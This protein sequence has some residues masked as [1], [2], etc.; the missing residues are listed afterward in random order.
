MVYKKFIKRDGKVFGPYYYESYRDSKGHVKTRFIS[1]PKKTDKINLFSSKKMF[2]FII[3]LGIIFAVTLLLFLG[4]LSY[5]ARTTGRV[6]DSNPSFGETAIAEQLADNSITSNVDVRD[7]V[8][9][10]VKDVPLENNKIM[11][12]ST[13]NGKIELNFDLLNYSEFVKTETEDIVEASGFDINVTES[14]EKY[15]WGY[16]VKLADLNF[17]ARIDVTSNQTIT[18]INNQTL[19]IGEAYLSFADLASQGYTLSINSPVLLN[20]SLV[21]NET[22]V[23]NET[24][25]T[26]MNVSNITE[27]V[28]NISIGNESSGEIINITNETIVISNESEGGENISVG[29][30]SVENVTVGNET[31]EV[32]I[33][34]SIGED[35]SE[36][37]SSEV[38]VEDTPEETVLG[39]VPGE[40][41]D[42]VETPVI[43]EVPVEEVTEPSEPTVTE[44]VVNTISGFVVH[45]VYGLTGFVVDDS[46]TDYEN[47]VSVYVQKN[48]NGTEY[49]I[50][51]II[52]LDPSLVF[53]E[54]STPGNIDSCQKLNVSGTYVLTRN[55]SGSLVNSTGCFNIT[56]SNVELNCNG[57]YIR[58]TG[59][60]KPGI[61]AGN[62]TNATVRNCNITMSTSGYGIQFSSVN[63]SRIV[64]NLV[65]SNNEGIFVYQSYNNNISG[66]NASFNSD[67][68]L[69]SFSSNQRIINNTLYSNDYADGIRLYT[70]TNNQIINNTARL[71]DHGIYLDTSSNNNI[72]GNIVS[73]NLNGGI[74]IVFGSSNNIVLNNTANLN[75]A[76]VHVQS[77]SDYNQV[78]NNTL[79]SNGNSISLSSASNNNFTNNNIWNC[80]NVNYACISFILVPIIF[81]LEE[82]LINLWVI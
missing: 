80:T 53:F 37:N 14:K 5:N 24:N 65:G 18:V 15:K 55:L 79:N 11:E 73:S 42:V 36:E 2:L 26:E 48:F 21:V 9:L 76:G 43:D 66:N 74:Y 56:V 68:I 82:L 41:T 47:T 8:D 28:T 23:I 34:E 51:D 81:F 32:V 75:S 7:S 30:E 19:R 78:T 13:P 12:F 57:Y 60:S 22:I 49:N 4:N 39:E 27:V 1:G 72:T 67:G 44:E 63:N 40:N 38:L 59:I 71:N 64:N 35:S 33:N 3:G 29:N 69:V 61:Y 62:V 31:T 25:V 52:N 17:I 50:G 46:E 77:G 10:E 54:Q 58:N 16:N 6:I 45:G 20:E 70:S